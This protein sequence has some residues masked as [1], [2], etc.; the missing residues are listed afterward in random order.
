VDDAPLVP[1]VPLSG[2]G[3][4][5]VAFLGLTS[6]A[7][8]EMLV[9]VPNT[10]AKAI[11]LLVM[12]PNIDRDQPGVVIYQQQQ[13]VSASPGI[14][15]FDLAAAET[16]LTPGR[17]YLWMFSMVC[18]PLDPSGNPY[19][20]GLIKRVNG[21]LEMMALENGADPY[22]RIN[23]YAEAGLWHE[24]LAS[25]GELY[26]DLPNDPEVAQDWRDL[27]FSLELSRAPEL[28]E[29]LQSDDIAAAPLLFCPE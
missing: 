24:T 1:L 8:P 26:C 12:D 7:A 17:D 5:E 6:S 20:R 10:P 15:K 18:D 14:L 21:E 16:E 9:Y 25:L 22:D 11:E 27:M 3:A 28:L 29:S 23:A 19:V 2:D 4:E 13:L